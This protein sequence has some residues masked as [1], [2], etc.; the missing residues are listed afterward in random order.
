VDDNGV[1]ALAPAGEGGVFAAGN[2]YAAGG[3]YHA[4]VAKY[5]SAGRFLWRREVRSEGMD[6]A[7]AAAADGSGGVFVVGETEGTLAPPRIGD[8]DIFIIHYDGDGQVLWARQL[9]TNNYDYANGAAA[10]GAGG[11]YITGTTWWAFGSQHF[12]YG[13]GYLAHCDAGGN[14]LWVTQFGTGGNDEATAVVADE[15]G[16]I[17][18]AGYTDGSLYQANQGSYDAYVMR[19]DAAGNHVWTNQFGTSTAE[20]ADALALDGQGGV[21]VG[22]NTFGN[23]PGPNAGNSDGFLVRLDLSGARL[24]ARQFGSA[25]YDY[26]RG[27]APDGTGGVFLAGHAEGAVG[28][29]FGGA[30]DP[31]A[32]RFNAGGDQMW[33][34]Q[35]GGVYG[36]DA[37][38]AL[39][40]GS[41]LY[42]GG[43][44]SLF[45]T[46]LGEA[47]IARYSSQCYANCDESTLAPALNIAD[48]VCFQ[49]RFAAGSPYANCDG[50]TSVPTLDLND[51][52]CFIQRYAAG[53]P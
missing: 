48:F 40:A 1:T 20:A 11:L 41:A 5:D 6:R 34:T 23:I 19:F 25:G 44:G 9:G 53:C 8:Y 3:P 15:D 46:G 31:F 35:L 52:V 18:V 51:F 38:C 50:S 2:T 13:D 28:G 49:Q 45:A 47:W 22:G 4:F 26:V 30:Y 33:A 37:L 29:P 12:G 27:V 24:W 16:H 17:F 10:D 36:E 39:A 7:H 21:F 42:M 32:L 43:R 14:L